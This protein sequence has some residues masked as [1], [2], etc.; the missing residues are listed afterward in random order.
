MAKTL[1]GAIVVDLRNKLGGHVFSKNKAGSFVRR[2][3]S[4]TQPFTAAQRLIR[5]IMTELSRAWGD[6]L[7]DAQRAA[8]KAF[9]DLHPV[10]DTFGQAVKLTGEQMYCKLNNVI[11]FLGGTRIDD[12]PLSLDVTS[13]TALTPTATETGPTFELAGVAPATL[14]ANELYVIW[15]TKQVGVGKNSIASLFAFVTT[16]A[17]LDFVAAT[18]DAAPTGAVRVSNTTTLTTV[19]P[20][21]LAPG[22]L[23]VVEGVADASFNGVFLCN[24][25]TTGSTIKL[26]NPGPDATSGAGTV[27]GSDS[28]VAEYEAK[29]GSLQ[30]GT[31]IGVGVRVQNTVTGASSPLVSKNI[32]VGA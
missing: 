21:G 8:W 5:G 11:L 16:R 3:V 18:I 14:Q 7:S 29:Y 13:I 12:P 22:D 32:T 28:I 9:G 24:T 26:T 6:V 25:G 27:S 23:I 20:H 10:T 15:A 19:A 17:A 4:P 31:R 2:K 1:M 30:A